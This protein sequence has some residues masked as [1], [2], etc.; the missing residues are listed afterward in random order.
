MFT[1]KQTLLSP[2]KSLNS[3]ACC[4]VS[5]SLTEGEEFQFKTER[6]FVV[7]LLKGSVKFTIDYSDEILLNYPG[8]YLIPKGTFYEHQTIRDAELF[9]LP[10]RSSTDLFA[11]SYD[12]LLEENM[13]KPKGCH[14]LKMTEPLSAYFKLLK[15][16]ISYGLTN[17]TFIELKI[18][19]LMIII[20]NQYGNTERARFF[21]PLFE[22][23]PTFTDFVYMNYKKVKN[24]KALAELS[25]Y[26]QS[27]FEKKFR[28][29]F[30]VSP[31]KWLKFRMMIDVYND[32]IKTGKPFK[33]I[34]MER[35]FASPSHFNN[36]C[37][38]S[39]GG[40]PGKLRK[41]IVKPN[42][43]FQVE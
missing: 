22:C 42:E 1:Q 18:R 7:F 36:F 8:L 11:M 25:C 21:Y 28:K 6:H 14:V 17:P 30:G 15:Y 9:V 16:A 2:L 39:L 10:A 32:L 20:K 3:S 19:E 24:V 5:L 12:G 26:S 35:G 31:S 34:S 41:R 33:E 43:F 40:T 4:F 29:V 37:K 27:G 13:P 38:M 23:E